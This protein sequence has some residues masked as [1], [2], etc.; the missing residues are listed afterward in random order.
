MRMTCLRRRRLLAGLQRH[1]VQMLNIHINHPKEITPLLRKRVKMIQ[2]AGIMM[3][4][5]T[6]CLKGVNDDVATMRE[7][8]MRSIEMG[9]RP[10]YVYSTDM[11]E[12]AHH[13]NVFAAGGDHDHRHPTDGADHLEQF[14]PVEVGQAEV[15]E[16]Q[17]GA[18]LHYGLQSGQRRGGGHDVVP[19]VGEGAGH[20]LA[21]VE[22]ILDDDDGGHEATIGRG[23]SCGGP[24]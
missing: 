21:D 5:Q 22:V 24:A 9:V 11:V 14:R 7:L 12:G 18:L 3:G 23:G 19:H 17:V 20:G 16:H 4:L 15:E 2:K 1:R 10:Y 8:F 13:F 6:V